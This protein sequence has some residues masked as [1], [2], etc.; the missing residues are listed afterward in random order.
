M[1]W[2]SAFTF[3]SIYKKTLQAWHSR[4]GYLGQ[5]NIIKL[6]KNMGHRIDQSKPSL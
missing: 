5:E 3:A 1:A 6:A 4:F 2:L